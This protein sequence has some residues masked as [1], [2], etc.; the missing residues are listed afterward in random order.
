MVLLLGCLAEAQEPATQEPNRYNYATRRSRRAPQNPNL[1]DPP[2]V[3]DPNS[4]ATPVQPPPQNQPPL[5]PQVNGEPAKS[6]AEPALPENLPPPTPAQVTYHNGLLT[7]QATNSTLA[8]LLAAIRNKTGI[9]FEGLEAGAPERVAVSVGPAPEGEVLAAI[10]DG[11]KFDYVVLNRSDS[12]E[13]VQRVLLTPRGVLAAPGSPPPLAVQGDDEQ[14]E[15]QAPTE[16][17][18]QD[19]PARPPLTQIQ[20]PQAPQNQSSPTPEQL[21]ERLKQMQQLQQQQQQLQQQSP[22]NQA[23][24]KPQGPQ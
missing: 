19:P 7:V 23:P 5:A 21:M 24:L 8:G 18:A 22:Q 15:Q 2:P 20:S 3:T 17:E 16:G 13:T 4:T 1:P 6:M 12:P 10:L 11:S 14:E 9:Q